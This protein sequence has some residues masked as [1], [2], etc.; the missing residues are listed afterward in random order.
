MKRLALVMLVAVALGCGS[1]EPDQN[2]LGGATFVLATF[3]GGALPAHLIPSLGSCSAMIVSASVSGGDGG[4]IS[5]TRSTTTPCFAGSPI[6]T[7]V[8]PG[9]MSVTGSAVTVTLDATTLSSAE[10][11]TGTITSSTLTLNST[12]VYPQS[13]GFVRQ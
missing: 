5:F 3:N 7:S 8:T 10:S 6:S 1:T 12:G 2:V 9:T 4:R 11:F 13:F